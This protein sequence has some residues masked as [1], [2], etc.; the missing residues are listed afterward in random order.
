[1][2]EI[3]DAPLEW[4][5]YISPNSKAVNV[6]LWIK[7][8]YIS[9]DEARPAEFIDLQTIAYGLVRTS[10]VLGESEYWVTV[11]VG[12]SNVLGNPGAHC[13]SYRQIQALC[14]LWW[15]CLTLEAS[16]MS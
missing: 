15:Q 5:I 14:N 3:Y 7:D 9:N 12:L 2:R 1:M 11:K 8:A 10:V 16:H 6:Q 4:L 13:L